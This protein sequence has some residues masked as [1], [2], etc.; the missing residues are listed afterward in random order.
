MIFLA[1][2]AP[3]QQAG[4]AATSRYY[5]DALSRFKRDDMAGAI[6]QLK[7]ALKIDNQLLPV[8]LLL[9]KALLAQGEVVAAEVAFNDA[10]RLGVDR[11]A[12]VVPLARAVV[13]QAKPDLLLSDPRFEDAD[14]PV[15]IRAQILILK[16]EA[17]ADLG[18]ARQA[19]KLVEEARG[20]APESADSWLTEVPM[21]V[22]ARQFKEAVAA[23]EQAMRLDPASADALYLRGSIVHARGDH[24]GALAWYAKALQLDPAHADSLIARAGLWV[25]A[26]KDTEALRDLAALA[27]SDPKDPRA[28]Y[29][30]ALVLE[31]KGDTQAAKAE[32]NGVVNQLDPVPMAFMR[33][34]PQLLLLGGLAHHALGRLEKALPYLEAVQRQQPG[35][36]ASKLLA[37]IHLSQG[38][39]DR[40]IDALD[41]YLAAYPG[42]SQAVFLLASAHLSQGRHARAA[43]LMKDALRNSDAPALRG[44]LGLSLLA[45]GQ[46]DKAVA[47]LE[48]SVARDP[49]Q[50]QAG[51]ALVGIYVHTG[52]AA[53]AAR[54]AD[55]LV[56]A[57]PRNPGLQS[58]KGTAQAALG[59]TK[60]AREAFA[61]A[62]KLDP[63]FLEPKVRLAGLDLDA[64]QFDA[65][66]VRLNEVLAAD[67]ANIDAMLMLAGAFRRSGRLDDAQRW[68]EKADDMA[69]PDNVQ[70]G[71]MLVEF[72][73][74]RQRPELA[75]AALARVDNRRPDDLSVMTL[76]ARVLLA[77]DDAP[78]ARS[79]L[80]RASALAGV[81]A[82]RL[83]QIAQLQL[84][85]DDLKGA[86][87]SIGKVLDDRP[88]FLPAQALMADI[89]LRQGQPAK[90]EQR[91]RQIIKQHPKLGLGYALLGDVAAARGQRPAAVEAY[92]KAHQIERSSDS[93]LRLFLAQSAVAPAAAHRLASDWLKTRPADLAVRRAQARS[94]ARAGDMK[95]AR[96]AFEALVKQ[97]P[98]DAEA[99]N[100]LAN[101]LMI[102]KDPG[103]LAMAERALAQAPEAPHVLGTAGWAAYHAGNNDRA[104]QLLREARLRDPDNGETRFF[105]ATVLAAKGRGAEA[106]SRTRGRTGRHGAHPECA[107]CPP[108]AEHAQLRGVPQHADL[109]HLCK[110]VQRTDPGGATACPPLQDDRQ[111]HGSRKD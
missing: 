73:L 57:N 48:K 64:R 59:K 8:Q 60:A 52:Q 20:L 96:A 17:A 19:L 37:Q 7:N 29:L 23:A 74:A 97:A 92:R 2:L 65:A 99:L 13:G 76:S 78:A 27:K 103:A 109:L 91:A 24:A 104:L 45:G 63:A 49:G 56:A 40:A 16:A 51:A 106:R 31:R 46:F 25:D 18:E 77:N 98:N 85:A 67:P 90:A 102:A 33:Y 105:L 71:I 55:A 9:G 28:A 66:M 34:R 26:R 83:V 53:K 108:A 6:I 82:P 94:L 95:G 70:P 30:R 72:L 10:L 12:V 15:E 110:G 89:D 11:S 39:L 107:G 69:G 47:E 43:E 14:L 36:P 38:R 81:L 75:K 101:V 44:V 100:N 86:A 111:T 1:T 62:L 61:A 50:V 35:S 21:R 87:H 41:S 42:D 68:I 84:E 32:L 4:D 3:A 80:D 58:L 88:D 54:V 93:L 22:R 5:E 79:V